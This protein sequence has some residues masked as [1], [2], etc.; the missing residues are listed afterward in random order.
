MIAYLGALLVCEIVVA[1]AKHI[2][3]DACRH[4]R[5]GGPHMFGHA[6]GGVQS[7]RCPDVLDVAFGNAIALQERARRI[8]TIDFEAKVATGVFFGQAQFSA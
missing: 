3:F 5:D 2:H 4:Q 7:N 1:D 8:C 6:G